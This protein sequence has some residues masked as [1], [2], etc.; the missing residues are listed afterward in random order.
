M[1]GFLELTRGNF[2]K[3]AGDYRQA[4]ALKEDYALAHYNYALVN[5]IY[6]QDMKMAVRHYKRYLELTQNQ[7]KK[8]ADWVLELERN[9]AKGLP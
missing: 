1:R 9:L 3:A 2:A 6:F 7:D 8:T 5:D 4:I